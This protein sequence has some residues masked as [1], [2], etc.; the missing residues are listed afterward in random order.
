M[1]PETA[2]TNAKL[3]RLRIGIDGRTY[4]SKR[5]VSELFQSCSVSNGPY[6]LRFDVRTIRGAFSS[7]H[8]C[9]GGQEF[10]PVLPRSQVFPGM[11][12]EVSMQ[13]LPLA[14]FVS[15]IPSF[16][17]TNLAKAKWVADRSRIESV[18]SE[19]AMIRIRV[20]QEHP[21]VDL[22]QYTLTARVSRYP[23]RC[24]QHGG[25]YL[26]CNLRDYI[27]RTLEI[28]VCHNGLSQPEIQ[29]DRSAGFEKIGLISFDGFRLSI[30]YGG[31]HRAVST[32]YLNPPPKSLYGMSHPEKYK[33]PYIERIRGMVD[34][35]VL[36]TSVRLKRKFEQMILH[37]GSSYDVGRIGA[38]LAYV[39]AVRFLGLKK[40]VMEEPSK[41]GKDLYTMG[42]QYSIQARMI[43]ETPKRTLDQEIQT[44]LLSLANKLLR[45]FRYN[46]KMVA[47]Y[48]ILSF[49]DSFGRLKTVITR[50]PR[51]RG[52]A[53]GPL[54]QEE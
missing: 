12:A 44:E 15:R 30:I 14:S 48:A 41:G 50:V 46:P 18:H 26:E 33:G 19:G 35:T 42:K 31:G 51:V 47:G 27:G 28:R 37:H 9:N 49:Q 11:T 1:T 40:V 53:L 32:F 10:R 8:I 34:E 16:V 43:K 20:T 25:V 7:Y 2:F 54:V 21:L 24:N 38:E 23:G 6:A 29:I 4:L 52:A 13:A 17:F 45:D 39:C 22:H 36:I 5:V 3:K